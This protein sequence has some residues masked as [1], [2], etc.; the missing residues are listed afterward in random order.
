MKS[1]IRFLFKMVFKTF[2]FGKANAVREHLP[3]DSISEV[4]SGRI[5]S[6]TRGVIHRGYILRALWQGFSKCF[7]TDFYRSPTKPLTKNGLQA[8][9]MEKPF[10]NL[11]Y[12]GEAKNSG[13]PRLLPHM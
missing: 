2:G 9:A 10:C 4:V 6:R 13:F 1:G 3:C 11:Y 8:E 5:S 7:A 12:G